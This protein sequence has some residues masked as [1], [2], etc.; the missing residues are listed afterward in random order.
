[1]DFAGGVF[2]DDVGEY[3]GIGLVRQVRAEADA[4][5]EGRVDVEGDGW[6][7]LVHGFALEADEKGDR[8][9]TLFD[10]DAFGYDGDE[11]VGAGAAGT[12]AAPDAI[13][14]VFDA[15]VLL[16]TLREMDHTGAVQGDDGLLG[17]VVQV[18]ANDE[19]GLAV[20]VAVWVGEGEVGGERD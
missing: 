14:H 20:A 12:A 13:L 1:M 2:E 4:D 9:S 17:I 5:V 6:A 11:A 19:E 3:G 7:E 8:V 18:L 16:G 15:G 10:A